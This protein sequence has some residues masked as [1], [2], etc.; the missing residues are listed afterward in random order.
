M[1]EKM[2]VILM[3]AG[4]VAGLV[5]HLRK[6]QKSDACNGCEEC[7]LRQHCTKPENI[8]NR[9]THVANGEK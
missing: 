6:Q 9:Q 7:K 2:L 8:K 3:V 5:W 1:I 4:A